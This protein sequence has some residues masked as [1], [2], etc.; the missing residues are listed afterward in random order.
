MLFPKNNIEF[1]QHSSLILSHFKKAQH[2]L[3]TEVTVKD[4]HEFSLTAKELLLQCFSIW[5]KWLNEVEMEF[6]QQDNHTVGLDCVERLSHVVFSRYEE[7]STH[8]VEDPYYDS[9]FVDIWKQAFAPEVEAFIKILSNK[10]CNLSIIEAY[11]I[12][13]EMSK[14]L[15]NH[16]LFVLQEIDNALN[17]KVKDFITIDR[18]DLNLYSELGEPSIV[19]RLE[20]YL[21][22]GL[23]KEIFVKC[24]VDNDEIEGSQLLKHLFDTSISVI[25][26]KVTITS[27]E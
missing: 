5:S 4:R 7:L 2:V 3:L 14:L 27:I 13:A 11:S 25:R 22:A 19:R 9:R 18:F 10:I 6:I 20:V 21:D 23:S 1:R 8:V 16:H 26:Q 24:Y 12:V 15:M 17:E